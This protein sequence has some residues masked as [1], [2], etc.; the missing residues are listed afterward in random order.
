MYHS[1]FI[2]FYHPV[3]DLWCQMFEIRS[4]NR[5]AIE[6]QWS[7]NTNYSASLAPK[8]L[9]KFMEVDFYVVY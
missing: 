8:I 7:L 6:K 4:K 3:F 5:S 1:F 9:K 2:Q